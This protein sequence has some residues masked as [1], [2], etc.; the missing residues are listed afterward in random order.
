MSGLSLA[1]VIV[2][3]SEASGTRV[4]AR[5][6]LSQG[7]RV[8]LMAGLL[9]NDWARDL[10]GRGGVEVLDSADAVVGALELQSAVAA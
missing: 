1:T 7:R 2:E 3:A 9:V 10:A 5:F 6:A 4:Q 8:F